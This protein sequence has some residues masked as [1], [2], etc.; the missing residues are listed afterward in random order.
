MAATIIRIV[1]DGDDGTLS[2]NGRHVA[3]L[4]LSG[5]TESGGV[6]RG[7]VNTSPATASKGKSTRFDGLHHS[8]THTLTRESEV[9]GGLSACALLGNARPRSDAGVRGGDRPWTESQFD[10]SIIDR[11]EGRRRAAPV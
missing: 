2:V 5:L 6:T 1:A 9:A 11:T 10:A 7:G 3:D 8:H 4:D